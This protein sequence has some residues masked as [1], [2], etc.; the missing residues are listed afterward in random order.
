MTWTPSKWDTSA[1]RAIPE[2]LLD[3]TDEVAAEMVVEALAAV[4]FEPWPMP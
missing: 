4:G 1:L 2:D 3:N